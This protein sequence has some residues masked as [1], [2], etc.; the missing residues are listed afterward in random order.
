[1]GGDEEVGGDGKWWV[2]RRRVQRKR[3]S[4]IEVDGDGYVDIWSFYV[5]FSFN[6]FDEKKD[7]GEGKGLEVPSQRK[8]GGNAR[9]PSSA[10][11]RRAVCRQKKFFGEEEG[12]NKR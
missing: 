6:F 2:E 7:F 11:E 9:R 5:I 10:R 8:V 3:M 4:V 12:K 1:M